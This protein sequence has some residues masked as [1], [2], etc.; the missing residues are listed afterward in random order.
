MT[1][2]DISA[3]LEILASGQENQTPERTLQFSELP[4]NKGNVASEADG[5]SA[6]LGSV[7]ILTDSGAS[8]ALT[9]DGQDLDKL[10]NS[11]E[12]QLATADTQKRQETSVNTTPSNK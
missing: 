4:L 9:F 12:A 10:A 1:D 6:E 3:A 11:L 8:G 7:V 2:V 5:T